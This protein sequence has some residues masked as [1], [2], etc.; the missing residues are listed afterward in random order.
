VSSKDPHRAR[1]T[2]D[3]LPDP[4]DAADDRRQVARDRRRFKRL[5][6][7]SAILTALLLSRVKALLTMLNMPC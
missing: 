6:R 2:L 7:S 1:D 3:E 5:S 4:G